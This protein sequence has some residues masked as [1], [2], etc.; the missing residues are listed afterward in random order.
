MIATPTTTLAPSLPR[1]GDPPAQAAAALLDLY[2]PRLFSLARRLCGNESDAEDLVQDVFLQAYRKW[3]SFRGQSSPGTW[4][5]AIAAH[6]CK[7]R[8]RRKGGSDRRAPAFSQ[9]SSGD[10]AP[11]L[12]DQALSPA[13]LTLEHEAT[14][15]VH[16]AVRDLPEHFRLPLIFKEVF[17]L[18]LGE[19]AAALRL[20]PATVKTRLH[21]AR[22]LLRRSLGEQSPDAA[23]SR[24]RSSAGQ[25]RARIATMSEGGL[26]AETRARILDR[27]VPADET[28][29]G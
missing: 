21:R 1:P 26:R 6:S 3:D 5:Y 16:R 4:L 15:A 22:D 8:L 11:T 18:T 20:N 19:T 17:G 24:R 28:R 10:R 27:L 14:D 2:G 25:L 23:R 29:T 13:G 12:C 7:E 9:F